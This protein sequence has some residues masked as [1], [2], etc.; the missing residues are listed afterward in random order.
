MPVTIRTATADDVPTI[1]E[2]YDHYVRN[3]VATFGEE[4]VT[5]AELGA[6]HADAPR[7]HLPWIVAVVPSGEAGGPGAS[8]S[9]ST[10]AGAGAGAGAEAAPSETVV[11]YAYASLFRPRSGWRFTVED[12]IYTR[13]GW[14]RRGV[15][16]LLLAELLSRLRAAGYR[17]VIAGISVD[18]ERGDG[19][20]SVALHSSFGFR[21]AGMMM[22]VGYKFGRWINCAFLQLDFGLAEG[23]DEAKGGRKREVGEAKTTA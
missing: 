7:L 20:G 14:Q 23:E 2:I 21:P 11:G 18:E 19:A 9:A 4:I 1:A 16:R 10:G 17:Q 15:G 5:A 8:S 12:S 13:E 3:T 22:Q 6:K